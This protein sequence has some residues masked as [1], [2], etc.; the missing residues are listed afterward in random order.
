MNPSVVQVVLRLGP[1]GTE[2]LVIELVSR[3]H[4]QFPMT[5]CC[6]DDAGEWADRLTP[7]GVTVIA[8]RRRPG[9]RPEVAVRLARI[10]RAANAAVVHCHH[11]SPFVYGR[12]ATWLS[13]GRRVVF[14]EHGRLSDGPP[15]GKRRLANR[16]LMA[17]R[18]EL[19]AVSHDLRRH[20]LGEG[21][22]ERMHVIWNGIDPGA[23]PTLEQ[24]D[25]VRRRLAIPETDYV[26]G[27]TA[28]LEPIKDLGTLVEAV[29]LTARRGAPVRAV[30]TGDGPARAGLEGQARALGVH[31]RVQFVGYR[32][33]ARDV[34]PGFDAYVNCSVSEGVSLTVLEAMAAERPVVATQVGGTPEVVVDGVT[35]ALVPPQRPARLADALLALRDNPPV[36]SAMGRAGR[37][38]VLEHFTIERMVRQYAAVY[39]GEVV[40][41]A[42]QRR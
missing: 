12:L 26:V 1:G 33:D 31:D 29:A 7:L 28:R 38:R 42:L 41:D 9:F 17:G 36:A 22:P 14:T 11:Y 40:S 39:R 16:V 10:L 19:F 32:D 34:L 21:V 6:L 37:A 2:R 30:I 3:L 4:A 25:S 35:G 18:S 8:L 24:R 5:V 20:L 15:S 27:T 23:A 13:P